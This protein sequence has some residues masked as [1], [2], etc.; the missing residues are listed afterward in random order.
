MAEHESS[1][2]LKRPRDTA[3][4]EDSSSDDEFGPAIPTEEPNKKAKLDQHGDFD[5]EY[6]FKSEWIDDRVRI[7]SRKVLSSI[8]DAI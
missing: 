8:A 7:K 1:A 6:E 5:P 3:D 4:A 2:S